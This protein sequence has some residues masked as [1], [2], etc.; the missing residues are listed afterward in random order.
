MQRKVSLLAVSIGAIAVIALVVGLVVI[1]MTGRNAPDTPATAGP[2]DTATPDSEDPD[3]SVC[4]LNTVVET[5]TIDT[6]APPT[7]WEW[8][9]STFITAENHVD[10]PAVVEEN[11]VRYCYAQTPTG[12]LFAAN[13]YGALGQV[14]PASEFAEHALVAGPFRDQVIH[15]TTSPKPIPQQVDPA[16]YR[17]T[18]YTPT[19]ATVEIVLSVDGKLVASKFEL[20]WEEGDWRYVPLSDGTLAVSNTTIDS[21]AG[22]VP[23]SPRD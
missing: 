17:L 20:R 15:D 9:E 4:G 7:E 3:A 22:Y 18:S 21:L 12:V 5:N 16:G 1:F 10:G 11:G 14:L 19:N 8:L 6:V 2:T 23:W 13:N